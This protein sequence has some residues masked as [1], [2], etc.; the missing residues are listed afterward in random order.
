MSLGAVLQRDSLYML[1]APWE[2]SIQRLEAL[3]S[4]YSGLGIKPR[5]LIMNRCSQKNVYDPLDAAKRVG[6]DRSM[7]CRIRESKNGTLAEFDGV[8][9][10]KYK[11]SGFKR[12]IKDLCERLLS[13]SFGSSGPGR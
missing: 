6:A 13:D 7:L 8:S 5:G 9:L 11:D 10:L 3:L 1:A 4:L 12:D 2:S